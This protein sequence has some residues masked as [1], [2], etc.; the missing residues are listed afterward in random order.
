MQGD[1][2]LS[3]GES[4]TQT[5]RRLR[6]KWTMNNTIA[7]SSKMWIS[8]PATWNSTKDPIQAKK[9]KKANINIR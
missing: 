9:R 6:K 5:E 1:W 3:E 2:E 8:A 4:G 7:T